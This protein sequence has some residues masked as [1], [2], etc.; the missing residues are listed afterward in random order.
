[1]GRKSDF[2]K[3]AAL[4]FGQQIG[5]MSSL[6]PEFQA[7]VSRNCV[8]W[9]GRIQPSPMS[10][11]YA[12]DIEYTLQRRPKVHVIHPKLRGRGP[13]EDIPHTFSDGSVCLHRH[14]DWTPMMFISDTI[15]PWLTLWLFYYEVWLATGQWLGGGD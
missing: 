11:A 13:E 5:R 12:V 2:F 4:S 7:S 6:H 1:M 8:T 3:S 10:N 9:T 14:E 15:V